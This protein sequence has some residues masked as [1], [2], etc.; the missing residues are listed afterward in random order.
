MAVLEP[1]VLRLLVLV[2]HFF[3]MVALVETVV[4][5]KITHI[6]FQAAEVVLGDILAQVALVVM[7]VAVERLGWVVLVEGALAAFLLAPPD[8]GG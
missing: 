4:L 5:G 7:S 6:F 3:R 1:L 2:V 8:S